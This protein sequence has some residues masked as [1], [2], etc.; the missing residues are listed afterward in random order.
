MRSPATHGG[1]AAAP[2]PGG[3]VLH[4]GGA[5]DRV[6]RRAE[7]EE[8]RPLVG[9]EAAAAERADHRQDERVVLGERPRP[10]GRRERA[11]ARSAHSRDL[12]AHERQVHRRRQRRRRDPEEARAR[13][14][15]GVCAGARRPPRRTPAAGRHRRLRAREQ[16]ARAR[17]PSRAAARDPSRSR[18]RRSRR[19]AA[20]PRAPARPRTG[21]APARRRAPRRAR[22]RRRCRT[23]GAPSAS[24]RRGSPP[25]TGRRAGPPRPRPPAPGERYSGVPTTSPACVRVGVGA[26]PRTTWRSRSRGRAAARPAPAPESHRFSGLRSRWTIPVGVGGGEPVEQLAQEPHRARRGEPPL[27]IEHRAQR[28]ALEQLHRE[29]GPPRRVLAEVEHL[30][31]VRRAE[32][33]SR[34]APRAGSDR[35]RRRCGTGRRGAPSRPPCGRRGRARPGRRSPCRP[36]RAAPRSASGRRGPLPGARSA[37]RP[38]ALRA[39]SWDPHRAHPPRSSRRA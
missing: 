8:R 3:G 5:L 36:C 26:A 13:P 23:G 29:V 19:A 2:R 12:D 32:P 16:R 34:P 33:R 11:R 6:G 21:P 22:A 35:A 25:R 7:G 15:A 24:R 31:D 18:A 14:P 38:R 27:A 20:R 39:R 28:L 4:R 9:G 10:R 37:P 17:R 1:R 30:D